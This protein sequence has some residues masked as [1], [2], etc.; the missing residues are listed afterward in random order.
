MTL[1]A[2]CGFSSQARLSKSKHNAALQGNRPA[3]AF[4]GLAVLC[5]QWRRNSFGST[6]ACC[7][8]ESIRVS[9]ESNCGRSKRGNAMKFRNVWE[10]GRG[11]SVHFHKAAQAP[12]LQKVWVGSASIHVER[13]N[14]GSSKLQPG[15]Q[16]LSG[17]TR[18]AHELPLQ[19]IDAL[20]KH[21][22]VLYGQ[23]RQFRAQP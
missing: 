14:T 22:L 11:V 10:G 8:H 18:G 16:Q 1:E 7:V 9:N 17:H 6:R 20:M 4:T 23:A 13:E 19:L 12:G 3:R 2:P 15:R 21:A 5:V